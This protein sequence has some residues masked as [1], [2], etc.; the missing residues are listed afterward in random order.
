MSVPASANLSGEFIQTDSVRFL[1]TWVLQSIPK[2]HN[3]KNSFNRKRYVRQPWLISQN[4]SQVCGLKS[5]VCLADAAATFNANLLSVCR[6]VGA[7]LG[8]QLG[9]VV[10][11][12][13]KACAKQ[14][15]CR[16]KMVG[17]T[18]PHKNSHKTSLYAIS[19]FC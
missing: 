17:T 19:S 8:R 10:E 1:R 6:H 11:L 12:T 18:K 2:I 5:Q 3:I 4:D 15:L 7:H 9:P 13:A 16:F 14:I